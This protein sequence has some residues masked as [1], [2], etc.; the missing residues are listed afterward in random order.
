MYG[1]ILLKIVFCNGYPVFWYGFNWNNV[2]LL[3]GTLLR[4]LHQGF[5]QLK[6]DNVSYVSNCCERRVEPC[7]KLENFTQVIHTINYSRKNS[8]IFQNRGSHVFVHHTFTAGNH[9]K[10]YEHYREGHCKSR[11]TGYWA[12]PGFYN[13]DANS[14]R[15]VWGKQS[16]SK[17]KCSNCQ[18]LKTRFE[19]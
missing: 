9:N 6:L 14:W 12:V 8:Y 15:K 13:M 11:C 18:Y 2:L 7:I 4:Q 10:L 3:C 16:A 17:A 1:F 5:L 19:Q